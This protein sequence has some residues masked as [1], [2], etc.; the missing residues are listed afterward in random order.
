MAYQLSS[1]CS[2]AQQRHLAI[3]RRKRNNRSA[4]HVV[5][6][7]IHHA[8]STNFYVTNTANV[9]QHTI[10]KISTATRPAHDA[11]HATIV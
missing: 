2:I 5:E 1:T 11:I 4:P 9:P 8:I 3:R 10:H 7:Q 6:Q